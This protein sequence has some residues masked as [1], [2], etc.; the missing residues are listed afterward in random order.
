MAQGIGVVLGVYAAVIAFL[1]W[2]CVIADPNDEASWGG[3]LNV[4][5]TENA[6]ERVNAGLQRLLPQ[7]SV[8]M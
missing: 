6:P 3:R 4:L 1:V 7:R 8:R 5:L 2:V